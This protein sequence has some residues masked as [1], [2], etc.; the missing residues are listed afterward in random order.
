MSARKVLGQAACAKPKPPVPSPTFPVASYLV[1]IVRCA[2]GTL[3]T[4]YTQ[5]PQARV[6]RHNEGKGA[7]YTRSR[8]PVRLVYAEVCGSKGEA[9]SREYA[10]KQLTREEKKRL[11]K[12]SKRLARPS[13]APRP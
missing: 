9:L 7:R 3:Y 10:I 1:Y 8:V 6:K 2:D 4:G 5:D 12:V 11:I 13:K